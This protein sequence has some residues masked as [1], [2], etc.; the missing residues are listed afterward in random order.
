MAPL[1][2]L[3]RAE[4]T[5]LM[6]DLLGHGG[7]PIPDRFAM[8]E[9]ADDV[10][11]YLD[12]R[13]IS[14][15]FVFGYSFGGSLALYLA[16]HFPQRIAGISVLA[17]KY[18]YDSDIVTRIAWLLEPER[19]RESDFALHLVDKC[20]SSTRLASISYGCYSDVQGVWG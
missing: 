8:S 15:T 2:D 9:I 3:V 13:K 10:L 16:R 19:I 5:V 12:E 14:R 4:T 20:P 1:A 17:A 11:A 6:P 7:R 18:M